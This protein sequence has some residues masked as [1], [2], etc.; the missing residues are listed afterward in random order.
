MTSAM[1]MGGLLEV[2]ITQMVGSLSDR[3]GRRPW[4][5]VFSGAMCVS[6][7]L[8]FLNPKSLNLA[9]ANRAGTW[10]LGAIFG[11]IAH[12]SAAL[13]DLVTGSELASAYSRLFSIIGAGVLVGLSTGS[14][15]LSATGDARF[16]MLARAALAAV[17]FGVD[18]VNLEET[19]P[20]EKRKGGG[21]WRSITPADCSPL[22]FLALFTKGKTL[23]TLA[24]CAT[25]QVCAEGKHTAEV[26]GMWV[27]DVLK[28][29]LRWQG[30]FMNFW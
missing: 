10:A 15:A 14:L 3:T 25:L 19:L 16:S 7:T 22:K 6:N 26:R 17:T 12:S 9:L 18:W 5:F 2:L 8:L 4:M 11:G 28:F 30:L 21:D 24:A 13:S 20:R 23:A 1:T 27:A 29:D